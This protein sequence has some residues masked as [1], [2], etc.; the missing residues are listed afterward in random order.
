M[1]VL[2]VVV[3]ERNLNTTTKGHRNGRFTLRKQACQS[4]TEINRLARRQYTKR[5]NE[6]PRPLLSNWISNITPSVSVGF[7]SLE[8]HCSSLH[9]WHFVTLASTNALLRNCDKGFVDWCS[10]LN[11]AEGLF[12]LRHCGLSNRLKLNRKKV[13]HFKEQCMQ[14]PPSPENIRETIP[15]CFQCSLFHSNCVSCKVL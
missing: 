15:D 12:A 11:F 4:N 8:G 13:S 1:R 3:L 6:K 14:N 9:D 5:T 10:L 7:M 2:H